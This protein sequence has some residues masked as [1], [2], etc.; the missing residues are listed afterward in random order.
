VG[1]CL[2]DTGP[3]KAPTGQ[4]L[5]N[6][7]IKLNNHKETIWALHR[8]NSN[9]WNKIKNPQVH[10]DINKYMQATFIHLEEI[11]NVGMIACKLSVGARI[12]GWKFDE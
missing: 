2:K 8:M 12:S 9:P 10:V 7:G 6:W 1:V 5:N 3:E 4:I 11:I